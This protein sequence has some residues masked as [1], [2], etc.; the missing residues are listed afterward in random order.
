MS[1]FNSVAGVA[2]EVKE[3]GPIE[4]FGYTMARPGLHTLTGAS[5]AGKTTTLRTVELASGVPVAEKPTKRRGSK[6]GTATVGG[7]RISITSRTTTKG[8]LGFEGLGNLD[9]TAIHWPQLADS[10]KRDAKRVLAL[11]RVAEVRADLSLFDDVPLIEVLDLSN[12]PTDDLVTMTS[13]IKREFE[14]AA[15]EK[16]VQATTHETRKKNA[17]ALFEGVDLD[18]EVSMRQ[19]VDDQA[20]AVRARSALAERD[21]NYSRAA[22]ANDISRA[23]LDE[24]GPPD[25]DVGQVDASISSQQ[26]AINRTKEEIADLQ[27]Q[28]SLLQDGLSSMQSERQQAA[29]Y[30]GQAARH[31]AACEAFEG[32]Q[33]VTAEDVAAAEAA[34]QAAADALLAANSLTEARQAKEQARQHS[35]DQRQATKDADALRRSAGHAVDQLSRAVN[36]IPGCPIETVLDDDGAVVLMVG[37]VPFD[38]KSDGERWKLVVPI[39]FKPGRIIVIPQAAFGELSRDAI[40]FLD[41]AAIDNECYILTAQVTDD[42]TEL[43][44]RPWSRADDAS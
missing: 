29:E 20:A 39:C 5:G 14:R 4:E 3:I 7:K 12:C 37:G 35:I 43:A 23:W 27:R 30:E 11:L 40:D 34:Q 17:E 33:P 16:E 6:K 42:G 24:N 1:D 18:V 10:R 41:Q 9:I 8:E 25:N 44:G 38:E 36:G 32:L 19:L 15:R 28:L 22:I 26:A 31:R 21:E 13:Y 2:I